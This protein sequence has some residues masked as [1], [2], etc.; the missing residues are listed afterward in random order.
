MQVATGGGA[1][2]AGALSVYLENQAA[3]LGSVERLAIAELAE[4]SAKVGSVLVQFLS[5]IYI[6]K[7]HRSGFPYG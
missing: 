4:S 7:V 3:A 1:V 5:H 6:K 2:E